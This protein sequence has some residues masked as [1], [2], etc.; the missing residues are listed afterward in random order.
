MVEIA[1]KLSHFAE[2]AIINSEGIEIIYTYN[3]LCSIKVTQIVNFNFHN[4]TKLLDL[5]SSVNA[6][7]NGPND[8]SDYYKYNYYFHIDYVFVIFY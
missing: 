8:T 4:F 6:R 5:L 7:D 3:L 1:A 2:K